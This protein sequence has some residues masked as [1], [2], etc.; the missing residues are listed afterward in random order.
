M[1][2]LLVKEILESRKVT[3]DLTGTVVTRVFDVGV[4]HAVKTT[5]VD[6]SQTT[7]PETVLAYA[8][9]PDTGTL[10]AY[11]QAH[12]T[13]S[14]LYIR[15]M[16]VEPNSEDTCCRLTVKYAPKSDDVKQDYYGEIW[17]WG[18]ASQETKITSVH[19]VAAEDYPPESPESSDLLQQ[20]NLPLWCNVG[21]AIGIK[22]DEVEGVDVYR[23]VLSIKVTK[24]FSP[25]QPAYRR[26]LIDM[27]STVNLDVFSDFNPFEVLFIGANITCIQGA[28]P[29]PNARSGLWQVE[30]NFMVKRTQGAIT[31]ALEDGSTVGPVVI[32]PW[33]YL[34]FRHAPKVAT[35]SKGEGQGT[36]QVKQQLIK[37]VH[38]SQV[39]GASNFSLL[40]LSGPYGT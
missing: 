15:D 25:L 37:S 32:R 31:M 2:N 21:T 22:D 40:N 18:I 24:Q 3:V 38:V 16:N 28:R 14:G 19:A 29:A 39:Y 13:I 33:D 6:V 10:F 36:A 9:N 1:P 17:E 12:P 20:W 34:W 26:T 4:K 23:P 8:L 27:Q 5:E 7:D 35:L 30:Y 11:D